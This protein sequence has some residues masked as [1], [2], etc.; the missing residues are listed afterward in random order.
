VKAEELFELFVFLWLGWMAWGPK[1]GREAPQD[2]P[3]ASSGG[4]P[5]K[6]DA[7]KAPE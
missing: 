5:G 6:P 4:A 3:R 2:K 1:F 7:A